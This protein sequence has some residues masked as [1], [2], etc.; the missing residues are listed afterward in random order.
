MIQIS[1]RSAPKGM[2]APINVIRFKG[3]FFSIFASKKSPVKSADAEN[4]RIVTA[5]ADSAMTG[6]FAKGVIQLASASKKPVGRKIA[7]KSLVWILENDQTLRSSIT[8]NGENMAH[9]MMKEIA[10]YGRIMI[11]ILKPYKES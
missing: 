5:I 10:I 7:N 11:S 2:T 1:D 3:G 9:P 8:A 6:S 4:S